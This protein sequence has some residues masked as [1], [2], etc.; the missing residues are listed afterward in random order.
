VLMCTHNMAKLTGAA[1]ALHGVN[2]RHTILSQ[3]CGADSLSFQPTSFIAV[4]PRRQTGRAEYGLCP[5]WG[6]GGG[7][8][9]PQKRKR[10]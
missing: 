6:P 8:G 7:G 2:P 5:R 9:G 1:S 10:F 3:R 4:L